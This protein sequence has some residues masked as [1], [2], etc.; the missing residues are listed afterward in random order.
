MNLNQEILKCPKCPF[1]P[2]I[3]II[4]SEEI[5]I[6]C[7]KGHEMKT[8][9]IDYYDNYFFINSKNNIKCFECEE[10]NSELFFCI[11]DEEYFCHNCEEA[12]SKDFEH[13]LLPI[14]DIN[15]LC[16]NHNNK[17]IYNF[18][19]NCS[20]NLCNDCGITHKKFNHNVINLKE[21][22]INDNDIHNFSQTLM[23]LK[24]YLNELNN[25]KFNLE[26]EELINENDFQKIN[27]L[28]EL[29]NH[30][31]FNYVYFSN[32]QSFNYFVYQNLKNL[33]F[34]FNI[35]NLNQIKDKTQIIKNLI[36]EI[37]INKIYKRDIN[38]IKNNTGELEQKENLNEENIEKKIFNNN[39]ENLIKFINNFRNKINLY[40]VN[41]DNN[42]KE[43]ININE[44]IINES[45][46]QFFDGNQLFNQNNL[47]N[48][49]KNQIL[50]NYYK[51]FLNKINNIE[52]NKFIQILNLLINLHFKKNEENNIDNFGKYLIMII[53]WV[54]GNSELIF[55][56]FE[57]IKDI[58]K[59]Q[60]YYDE[61]ILDIIK[62]TINNLDISYF[63]KENN[64]PF[65]VILESCVRI[66]TELIFKIKNGEYK[67]YIEEINI[68]I[69][70][71]MRLELK[72]SFQS[73]EILNLEQ[74][75][76]IINLLIH[77]NKNNEIV[78]IIK[79]KYK[80]IYLIFENNLNNENTINELIENL[81]NEYIFFQNNLNENDFSNII[82]FLF[83]KKII[84]IKNEKFQHKVLDLILKNNELIKKSKN[85]LY[86][87]FKEKIKIRTEFEIIENES[88]ENLIDEYLNFFHEK[89][90]LFTILNKQKNNILL[91]EIIINLFESFINIYFNKIY[92]D[93][94]QIL[95]I[96][97]KLSL[98][99]FIKSLDFID[100]NYKQNHY[101]QKE[102]LGILMTIS[103]VKIYLTKLI[104][105]IMNSE[106]CV[107]IDILS[108]IMKN[109]NDST[110]NKFR[111]VLKLYILKLIKNK[112]GSFEKL[113]SFNFEKLKMGF[114]KDIITCENKNNNNFIYQFIPIEQIDTYKKILNFF[115]NNS[116]KKFEKQY[117]IKNQLK[118]SFI[119]QFLFISINKIIIPFYED[120][121]YSIKFKN[122]INYSNS[123][124]KAIS[125][126]NTTQR[127]L[128][129]I[130]SSQLSFL[131]EIS[132]K[133]YT[134]FLYIFIIILHS[135]NSPNNQSTF[136]SSLLNKN[137]INFINDNYI[138][139]ITQ[140]NIFKKSLYQ[141][142]RFLNENDYKSGAYICSC[143][144][145]YSILECGLPKYE[146]K[147]DNCKSII[148]GIDHV[149]YDREGHFRIFKDKCQED[150]VMKWV[151]DNNWLKKNC[152]NGNERIFRR[153]I[154]N[155]F[156]K[157]VENMNEDIPGMKK[158]SKDFFI[159]NKNI[160]Q[161][162]QITIR[163]IESI[164]YE[165][166]LLNI[167]LEY[168]N[169][170]DII[171]FLPE[172]Y[173]YIFDI[174]RE[175]WNCLEI[176]LQNKG[177]KEVEIFLNMICYKIGDFFKN[178]E[179]FNNIEI[180]NE[181]EKK[182]NSIIE[183]SILDF[184]NY[185]K[186]YIEINNELNNIKLNSIKCII[187]EYFNPELY[188]EK[189]YPFFKYFMYTKYPSK[190]NLKKSLELINEYE[191]KYPIITNFINNY[192]DI[193]IL[194]NITKINPFINSMLN[195]YSY[196][197]TRKDG[198]ILKIKDELN[199]IDNPIL[200]KQFEE[201]KKGWNNIYCYI[202]EMQK[203][204]LFKN[205]YLLKYICYESMK[206]KDILDNDLIAN[207]LKDDGE[208]FFGM[209]ISAVYQ[210]FISW[211]NNFLSSI[212]FSNN[213]NRI[214]NSFK[215]NMNEENDIYLEEAIDNN[216]IN[217]NFNNKYSSYKSFDEIIN[218]FSKRIC[219]DLDNNI[220]YNQYKYIEYNFDLI[221][222]ELAKI[223]LGNQK[224]FKT[225][226]KFI[227]YGFEAF[228]DDNS[229]IINE[230]SKKYQ[231]ISLNQDEIKI[232][233][234]FYNEKDI[235]PQ[236]LFTLQLLIS[237]L[238]NENFE[239]NISLY[240]I[241]NKISKFIHIETIYK[242]FFEKNNNFKLSNLISIFEYIEF[243]CFPKLINNINPI[244]KEDIND[245]EIN[246]INLYFEKNKDII[247]NKEILAISIRRFI[248]RFLTGDRIQ[249]QFKEDENI[250]YFIQ[251]KQ[252]FWSE[253]IFNNSKFDEE[254]DL[255]SK[256]FFI[257]VNQS[258]NF[259][260]YLTNTQYKNK[261][262]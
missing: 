120:S 162:N 137:M 102:H 195:I 91:D 201:F 156:K 245:E 192:K 210:L 180:R 227:I 135:L 103:Y 22:I 57:I 36:D 122:F 81:V 176:E 104:N 229:N 12:H 109:V 7:I 97:N 174:L 261:N 51:I 214:L 34:N 246:K 108:N 184:E 72:L 190:K 55:L 56:I 157:E 141:I 208:L 101:Y 46:K 187:E 221:E 86:F 69:E 73:K 171:N 155:D 113:I 63:Y 9:L 50:E 255:M 138:P 139:C 262:E 258:L 235:F 41:E 88:Y 161:L 26:N 48:E 66:I 231:Q 3:Q 132:Q 90:N 68:L 129:L 11:E 24:E 78:E 125:L 16:I 175:C 178:Y 74:L 213:K 58:L 241:I 94:N 35:Q 82:I 146:F 196:K 216:I 8:N 151:N 215:K 149:P 234:N 60:D 62:E 144:K 87:I 134:F 158:C 131:Y 45:F 188:S 205:K 65:N 2:L 222:E 198:K 44:I 83:E 42:I 217:F 193:E 31:L 223:I 111:Y 153:K 29:Y 85:I 239:N 79:I 220:N 18:C 117:V 114:I 49:D 207:V 112:L 107:L 147:C 203:N 1:I 15:F 150:F 236:F 226:Q 247:I 168:N 27:G 143:G 80:E 250:L 59:Y 95:Q 166:L 259:Y 118:N 204:T 254:I 252:E 110:G 148:G 232:L 32:N 242:I 130:F 13:I 179:S 128:E 219:I 167:E 61:N 33:N 163:L 170:N 75:I 6:K 92:D 186:R 145:W 105:M 218:I 47:T 238:I 124:I 172:N 40:I 197:I 212:K 185:K 233:Y 142:E 37:L 20:L 96:T 248:S 52:Y 116:E 106:N 159:K 76:Q 177:I 84:Q 194:Q 228:I 71:I 99:Y 4:S 191:T 249:I 98:E 126:S 64:F 19:K 257:K 253:T 127:L 115:I 67:K 17:K 256:S 23:N 211:Q 28:F 200:N 182:V 206:P 181:F 154:F 224:Y 164:I 165:C 70:K 189:D 243:L 53:I 77:I 133:E 140:E 89:N 251:L 54:E 123:I 39:L 199:R 173:E 14:K 202:N 237:Y 160:R 30:I 25:V 244:Y 21:Y 136:L 225:N 10:K 5:I 121:N 169:F 183:E 152:N 209:Y 43:N 240:K 230:F 260:R 38:E 100:N 93:E 119:E